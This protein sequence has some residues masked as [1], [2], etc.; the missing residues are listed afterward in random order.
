MDQSLLHGWVSK[1]Q[2]SHY[3]DSHAGILL[4]PLYALEQ[5]K[6]EHCELGFWKSGCRIQSFRKQNIVNKRQWL[7]FKATWEKRENTCSSI[8]KAEAA[9]HCSAPDFASEMWNW[10]SCVVDTEKK[11]VAYLCWP[12]RLLSS[13][14][15]LFSQFFLL[16]GLCWE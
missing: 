12:W 15:N 2:Q 6:T 11:Q 9:S 1:L 14:D 7:C 4:L 10:N 16:L 3:T 5:A 8:Q 13:W